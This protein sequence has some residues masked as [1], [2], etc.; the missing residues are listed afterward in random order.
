MKIN[1]FIEKLNELGSLR[2]ERD[3]DLVR[4]YSKHS[5]DDEYFFIINCKYDSFEDAYADWDCLDDDV[6][7]VDLC[8][9]LNLA[10]EF[11]KTP[12]DER[13]PEKK[14]RVRLIGFNSDNGRQYLTTEGDSLNSKFFACALRSD[15]KQ[16]FTMNEINQL[17]NS[18]RFKAIPWIQDLLRNTELVEDD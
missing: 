12:I 5:A 10:N 3:N 16:E 6:D 7:P 8:E 13:F 9:A 1:E 14:Y 4:F 17:A 2:A 18:T 11:L 15:L